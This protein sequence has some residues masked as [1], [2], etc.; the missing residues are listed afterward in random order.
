MY[1]FIKDPKT[2]LL[3]SIKGSVGKRILQNYLLYMKGGADPWEVDKGKEEK[4]LLREKWEDINLRNLSDVK[5]RKEKYKLIRK[6]FIKFNV[7][8]IR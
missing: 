4:K 1:N 2:D 3:V 8:K 7:Q 5:D 6:S